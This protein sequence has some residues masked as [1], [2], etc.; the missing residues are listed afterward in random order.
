MGLWTY[1]DTKTKAHVDKVANLGAFWSQ[2]GPSWV[3]LGLQLGGPREALG[4]P[5]SHPW[6]SCLALGAKMAPR[7]PKRLSKTDF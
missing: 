7:P 1:M 6:G 3:Q 5:V 2:L 4:G